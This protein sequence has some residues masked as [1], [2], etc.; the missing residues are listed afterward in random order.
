[1]IKMQQTENDLRK[2]L[3]YAM[4]ET[5]DVN[6]ELQQYRLRATSQLQMK[7]K[8]IQELNISGNNGSPRPSFDCDENDEI[9]KEMNQLRS[10]RDHFQSELSLLTRRFEDS[11][12]F[13]EKMEHKHRILTAEAEDTILKLNETI[14][15]LNLK[16]SHY[17][18]EIKLQ[19]QEIAQ[20][21]DELFEQSNSM[22]TKLHEK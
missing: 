8:L 14:N 2:K 17:E 21:R 11:R 7:E 1:M 12:S 20:V 5:R 16:S 19:K 6:S 15:Q 13:I 18:D 4:N 10:Q 22:T 3:D 9:I